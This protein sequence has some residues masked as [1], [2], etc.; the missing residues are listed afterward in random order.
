V[1]VEAPSPGER[2]MEP[3]PVVIQI[4]TDMKRLVEVGGTNEELIARLL[5]IDDD[6]KPRV[7]EDADAGLSY[8]L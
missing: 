4:A 2:P 6:V 1:K 5:D 8:P 3:A 7:G